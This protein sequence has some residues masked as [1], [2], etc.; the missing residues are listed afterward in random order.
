[1]VEA[2]LT[3]DPRFVQV[4]ATRCGQQFDASS[5]G[6]IF[7]ECPVRARSFV[8]ALCEGGA[9]PT[10]PFRSRGAEVAEKRQ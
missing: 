10:K 7:C 9:Q 1:I 5:P 4:R 6:T 3:L 2:P 8:R